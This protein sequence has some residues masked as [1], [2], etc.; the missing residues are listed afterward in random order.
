MNEQPYKVEHLQDYQGILTL[1]DQHNGKFRMKLKAEDNPVMERWTQKNESSIELEFRYN[2]GPSTMFFHNMR[3]C[4]NNLQRVDCNE[5][6]RMRK[7][8]NIFAANL[9][10]LQF[11]DTFRIKE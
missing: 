1:H 3:T 9:E 2:G 7:R 5:C 4:P 6:E 10:Q 11:G 8:Y